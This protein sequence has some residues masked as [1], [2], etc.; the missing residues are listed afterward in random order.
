[1]AL[2][3]ADTAPTVPRPL[4]PPPPPSSIIALA[5]QCKHLSTVYLN[6]LFD[7]T[8]SAIIALAG[9]PLKEIYMS[10]CTNI[11]DA[12]IVV[13]ANQCPHLT[14]ISLA[15]CNVTSTS[16]YALANRCPE[17]TVIYLVECTNVTSNAI[18]ALAAGCVR[19]RDVRSTRNRRCLPAL[20][21]PSA[22]PQPPTTTPNQVYLDGCEQLT[23][24]GVTALSERCAGLN[25]VDLRECPLVT[26]SAINA[27]R[28]SHE[29]IKLPGWRR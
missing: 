25:F 6:G 8:N 24:S 29:G 9:C 3:T 14:G 16:V 13:L 22:A 26:E 23:D 10:G 2:Q 7:C 11:S 17:L 27:L 1:V 12:A 15:H 5:D 28:E 4:T 20:P 19:L 21:F 18:V